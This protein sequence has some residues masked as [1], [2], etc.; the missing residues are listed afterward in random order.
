MAL[1]LIGG[2]EAL[3]RLLA[4]VDLKRIVALT[5]VI[6]M[7]WLTSCFVIGGEAFASLG[8]FIALA[9]CL[10][11]A[12]EFFMVE[13]LSRRYHSRDLTAMGS[14]WYVAPALWYVS[15]GATL[16]TIGFPGTSLFLA[17]VLYL[18]LGLSIAPAYMLAWALLLLV[19][20]PI[21]FMRVWV[22]IWFGFGGGGS[23]V[24]DLTGRE[25]GVFGGGL[26]GGLVLGLWPD[27]FL[28]GPWA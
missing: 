20:L 12:V 22:P 16:V 3:V 18:G 11:T 24:W 7:N 15:L 6:E 26:G 21:Y 9:H 13:A 1:C 2:I 28:V 8:Y 25:L 19:A 14:L 23:G 17:K 10:T 27:F 4:Q 5:T